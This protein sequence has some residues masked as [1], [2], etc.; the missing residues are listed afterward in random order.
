[1]NCT[2]KLFISVLA[3]T[4]AVGISGCNKKE[5]NSPSTAPATS[6]STKNIVKSTPEMTQ[7]ALAEAKKQVKELEAESKVKLFTLTS[8]EF[9]LARTQKEF[10]SPIVVMDNEEILQVY[11]IKATAHTDYETLVKKHVGLGLFA[12]KPG[13]KAGDNVE[14]YILVAFKHLVKS[15]DPWKSPTLE[16]TSYASMSAL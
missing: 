16:G 10:V 12:V 5:S 4:A 8:I 3:L 15:Q 2:K 14:I 7:L 1:M 6:T 13:F 9:D 11:S